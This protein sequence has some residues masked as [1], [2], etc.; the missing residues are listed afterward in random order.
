[1]RL[2]KNRLASDDGYELKFKNDIGFRD[3]R[4]VY[5]APSFFLSCFPAKSIDTVKKAQAVFEEVKISEKDA[6]I[7][8]C[9]QQYEAENPLP[10]I[11][12]EEIVEEEE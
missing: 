3:G 8:K 1:M 11:E 9:R 6:Y 5:I 7:E 10:I 2:I 12:K 4:N